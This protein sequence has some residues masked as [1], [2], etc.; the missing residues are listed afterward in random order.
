MWLALQSV[1][2]ASFLMPGGVGLARK[3]AG[4]I[5][6]SLTDQ[7]CSKAI[8][9]YYIIVTRRIS[10]SVIC[11]VYKHAC[12]HSHY[13]APLPQENDLRSREMSRALQARVNR[14]MEPCVRCIYQPVTIFVSESI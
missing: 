5:S 4:C 8:Y 9:T 6:G 2:A 12:V 10:S 1:T 11:Q 3:Q 14:G 13:G 7:S